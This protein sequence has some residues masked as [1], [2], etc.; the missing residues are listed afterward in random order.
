[1]L[2]C[3]IAGAMLIF[4]S[5]NPICFTMYSSLLPFY[6]LV[7]KVDRGSFQFFFSWTVPKI[8]HPNSYCNFAQL[9]FCFPCQFGLLLQTILMSYIVGCVQFQGISS[10]YS[11]Q[12][13]FLKKK[14]SIGEMTKIV[15]QEQWNVCCLL[16]SY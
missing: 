5:S 15:D 8:N 13:F 9:L 16:G 10:L 7:N 11:S 12:F 2:K 3:L 1:M 4:Q 6:F 14:G